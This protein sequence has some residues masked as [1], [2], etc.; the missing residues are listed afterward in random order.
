MMARGEES[1]GEGAAQTKVGSA[2]EN[3]GERSVATG[4]TGDE[5][6]GRERRDTAEKK[7]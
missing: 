4:K 6:R 5:K 1:K 7:S 3:V 2:T